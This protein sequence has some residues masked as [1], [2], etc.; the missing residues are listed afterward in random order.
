MKTTISAEN[1]ATCAIFP[2][3]GSF[4]PGEGD[5]VGV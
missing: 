1:S 4:N 5:A 3:A 2:F